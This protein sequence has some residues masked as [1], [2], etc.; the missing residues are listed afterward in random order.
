M[1]DCQA[2]CCPT[3]RPITCILSVRRARAP[4][5]QRH[6]CRLSADHSAA[7]APGRRRARGH[8]RNDRADCVKRGCVAVLG[9]RDHSHPTTMP[10]SFRYEPGA[11]RSN[12][13]AACGPLL[14]RPFPGRLPAQTGTRRLREADGACG[15]AINHARRRRRGSA[16][17]STARDGSRRLL[18]RGRGSRGPRDGGPAIVASRSNQA[19]QAPQFPASPLG[20][21]AGEG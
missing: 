12:R 20:E 2:R 3:G 10:P 7:S 15:G 11:D 14:R 9:S 21:N 18:D 5:A 4:G 6:V 17:S 13:E 16:D 8:R 19:R 1:L